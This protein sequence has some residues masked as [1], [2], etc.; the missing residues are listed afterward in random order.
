MLRPSPVAADDITPSN[1]TSTRGMRQPA[2]RSPS[3]GLRFTIIIMK[4]GS[5]TDLM[6]TTTVSHICASSI[7][8]TVNGSRLVNHRRLHAP[9][10]LLQRTRE[11]PPIRQASAAVSPR[12]PPASSPSLGGRTSP[13]L[14]AALA[15]RVVKAPDDAVRILAG[16]A[17]D[18]AVL[19]RRTRKCRH[20]GTAPR[21]RTRTPT[22][23]R[24]ALVF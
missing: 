13:G 3:R 19:P 20:T 12:R 8:E 21:T 17:H 23:R 7:L 6:F 14:P 11:I 1:G 4:A 15:A 22:R 18:P 24:M 2:M 10:V 16:G 5:K 9:L